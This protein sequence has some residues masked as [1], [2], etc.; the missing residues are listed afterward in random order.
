[1]SGGLILHLTGIA[2]IAHAYYVLGLR[3]RDGWIGDQTA[4]FMKI[5]DA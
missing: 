3:H 1:V 2:G 5:A 4:F